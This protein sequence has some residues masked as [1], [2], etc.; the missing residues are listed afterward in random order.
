V[1]FQSDADDLVAG[2]SNGVTDI[3]LHDVPVGETIRVTAAAADASEHPALDAAGEDL[4]YD[5]RNAD[6]RRQILIDGLW[7]DT[8]AESASLVE[9]GAGML[10]DN[11]HPAISADGRYVAY[12]E[13]AADTAEPSCQVH[14]YDR[15]T[16]W[17]RRTPCPDALAADSERA[18]PYFSADGAEVHWHLSGAE[19]P[20][21]VPNA[22]LEEQRVPLP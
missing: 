19:P 16:A 8:V 5:Q 10:L 15:D 1:V 4:L 21:V 7:D 9:D 17:Y 2:D 13:A 11:H 3:F 14:V 6:G 12:L 22:L 20:V 18:R